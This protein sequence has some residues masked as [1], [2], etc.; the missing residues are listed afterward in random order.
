MLARN[1]RQLASKFPNGAS[2]VEK[3]F[4]DVFFRWSRVGCVAAGS[5]R[6]KSTIPLSLPNCQIQFSVMLHSI[7]MNICL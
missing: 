2:A 4:F 7:L 6:S 3:R 5:R 1:G